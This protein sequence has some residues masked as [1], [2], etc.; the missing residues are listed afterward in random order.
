MSIPRRTHPCA[1]PPSRTPQWKSP[2]SSSPTTAEHTPER[3]DDSPTVK[4]WCGLVDHIQKRTGMKR[5]RVV[6]IL[7]QMPVAKRVLDLAVAEL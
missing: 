4:L 5:E 6:S 1:P 2:H 3:M 7:K